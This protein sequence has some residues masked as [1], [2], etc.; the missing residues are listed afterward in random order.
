M[1]DEVTGTSNKEQLGL[2]LSYIIGNNAVQWPY[3]YDEYVGCK[4]ITWESVCH[5]I[6]S[7]LESQLL[8]SD[9]WAQMYDGAG[10][11]C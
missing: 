9:C 5:E 11:V 3:E 2:I 7:L 8:V 4:S 1:T 6:V 10:R